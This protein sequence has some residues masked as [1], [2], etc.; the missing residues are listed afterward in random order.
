MEQ[1]DLD[2]LLFAQD[3]IDSETLAKFARKGRFPLRSPCPNGCRFCYER[4]MSR[5]IPRSRLARMPVLTPDAFDCLLEQAAAVN[6]PLDPG[7]SCMMM[8][9]GSVMFFSFSDFFSQGLTEA[10]IDRLLSHNEQ[11][12]PVPYLYTNAQTL[13]PE[14][15]ARL[16]ERHP[17]SFRLYISVFT[18]N[19]DI[20]TRLVPK[21]PGSGHLLRLLPRLRKAVIYLTHF[22]FEQTM[23]D[24]QAVN[25]C[26]HPAE[27]PVVLLSRLH[28][29]RLHPP[30][31]RDL[32]VD[33]S[34]EALRLAEHL[35][36]HRRDLPNIDSIFFQF[37]STA[38]AWMFREFLESRL[39]ALKL[40]E[41]DVVLCSR[42]AFPVLRHLLVGTRAAVH[43]VA[44]PLGGSTDFATT[45][46][47][48]NLI[49]RV[50]E[51]KDGGTPVTRIV[52]P[53]SMWPWS[54]RCLAG[55]TVE[56]IRRR[57]PDADVAV[58]DIPLD[59]ISCSLSIDNVKDFFQAGGNAMLAEV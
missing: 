18:F 53:S 42:A 26:A 44:D 14:M 35:T 55:G 8:P 32:A 43:A 23:A 22:S 49:A 45:V 20:K 38:Y 39:E 28:Y 9:D 5:M 31:V 3:E 2:G 7:S 36:D 51:L 47:T 50:Q 15:A 33:G 12:P 21:W 17:S 10:Q 58:V 52:V 24:L 13:D 40:G 57:F 27:P 29:N 16:G 30:V 54:G 1:Y 41:G 37:P 46:T 19:D 25:R 56:D 34:A 11:R 48:P 4:N 6:L 59:Y